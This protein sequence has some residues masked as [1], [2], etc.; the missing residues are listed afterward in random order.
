MS[1][2]PQPDLDLAAAAG[3][4]TRRGES[5]FAI[6]GGAIRVL[7]YGSGALVSLATAAILVRHLGIDG[8]GRYVTVTALIALVGGVTEAGI[9]VHG[10]REFL[11]SDARDRRRLIGNLIAM[12]L[13]LTTVGVAL[14]ICFALAIGYRQ[15]LVL[16]AL[17]AGA[18]LLAQVTA[19]VLS[20]SLQ[21]H[22]LL[23]RLT[24][25]ELV[26]RVLTLVLIAALSL[27]GANLLELIAAGAV[28]AVLA[29]AL[30]ASLTRREVS[31]APLFHRS[32]W[33]RLLGDLSL[34]AIALSIAA[35][36]LYVTVLVM[37]AIATPTQTGLFA[38]S[39]RVVQA[40]LAI[41]GLLLTAIFPLMTGAG[42]GVDADRNDAL[43]KV[44]TVALI[45]GAGMALAATL[46]AGFVIEAVAG[47]AGHGAIGVL[48]IQALMFLVS[49]LFT[50]NALYLVSIRR[51]R[52]LLVATSAALVLDVVLALAL[53]PSL[54]AEGGAIADVAT[55]TA[56]ALA[57]TAV[58]WRLTPAGRLT[59]SFLSALMLACAVSLSVLLLPIGSLAQAT[60]ATAIYLAILLAARAVPHEVI[61][62]ARR[63]R[64]VR[65]TP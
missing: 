27:A 45:C 30:I 60:V 48:R 44:L 39:F 36:Y 65:T 26:R 52:P 4:P 19:D 15:V 35:I 25:V 43:G 57:L 40:G 58:V 9:L 50:A 38:T 29:L 54:G 11:D 63:A 3:P 5:G 6:R 14:A 49:F 17:V 41:P 47:P 55:E 2:P 33:R 61:E 12:R 18:G 28:S 64:R 31:P 1:E 8:F 37:S 62:A 24:I 34:Y 10:I 59:V 32:I 53:I 7:G 22:M 20:V 51:Y 16:G 13:T 23:G 46:G 56:A 42:R 21:A